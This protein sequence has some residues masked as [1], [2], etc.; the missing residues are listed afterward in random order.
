MKGKGRGPDKRICDKLDLFTVF[1][2]T[3]PGLGSPEKGRREQVFLLEF[4]RKMGR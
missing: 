2:N 4:G 1:P 3:N